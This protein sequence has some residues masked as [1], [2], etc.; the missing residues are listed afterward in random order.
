[1]RFL[2]DERMLSHASLSHVL[3]F[4]GHV[5]Q[6]ET[7]ALQS[8]EDAREFDHPVSICYALSEAI[9]T[10]AILI[11]DDLMLEEAV[12]EMTLQT[13]RHSIATWRARAEMWQ[14]LIELKSGNSSAYSQTIFPAMTRIGSKRFYVSLTPFLSATAEALAGYGKHGQALELIEPA[15]ERAIGIKD[16][17]SLP[18][19]LRAKAELLRA[20]Q[21]SVADATVESLLRE[22]LVK[23]ANFGFLSWQLRCATS[24]ASF[25]KSQGGNHSVG[26]VIAP[27]YQRFNEGLDSKDLKAARALLSAG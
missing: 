8:L 18:E 1:M 14:G 20:S 4:K 25:L 27:L 26:E 7:A 17:C 15:L 13:R 16:Q 22:A 6:A 10:L 24:L 23:A 19:L 5:D 2:Y 9:C 3:W 21:G 12:A 11:G